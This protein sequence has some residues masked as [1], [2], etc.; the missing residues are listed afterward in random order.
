[1]A[2][3]PSSKNGPVIWNYGSLGRPINKML[4]DKSM[5]R[6]LF[7][8]IALVLIYTTYLLVAPFIR[9]IL[10]SIVIAYIFY[11]LYKLISKNSK[12]KKLIALALSIS[13]ILIFSLLSYP[14]IT[15]IYHD[16]LLFMA[17]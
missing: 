7:I 6:Y 2:E 14:Y 10:A 3:I 4:K 16:S 9:I 11:P 17:I 13:I 12:K 8:I 5:E 15:Q 1:M